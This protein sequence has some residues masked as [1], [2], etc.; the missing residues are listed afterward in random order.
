MKRRIVLKITATFLFLGF[1]FAAGPSMAQL[2][3]GTEAVKNSDVAAIEEELLKLT[4]PDTR[5]D[6]IAIPEKLPNR[7]LI[8]YC[9][10]VDA[11]RWT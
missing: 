11:C 8:R 9:P 6:D 2:L 10:R 1:A 5:M 7:P 3:S 4:Y